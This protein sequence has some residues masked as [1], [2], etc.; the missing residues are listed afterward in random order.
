MKASEQVHVF[1]GAH[2]E[3]VKGL[4]TGPMS[5]GLPAIRDQGSPNC[6]TVD[7]W[8]QAS[9]TFAALTLG[10]PVGSSPHPDVSLA[11]ASSGP[12]IAILRPAPVIPQ[13]EHAETSQDQ[14][15]SSAA[16]F[17]QSSQTIGNAD[18]QPDVANDSKQPSRT[19][20]SLREPALREDCPRAASLAANSQLASAEIP[21]GSPSG[22]AKAQSVNIRP[23][24]VTSSS[25]AQNS[26]EPAQPL[27]RRE[28]AS[29]GTAE[30][31]GSVLFMFIF[32]KLKA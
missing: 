6:E 29:T 4:S 22:K 13:P 9:A 26:P 7:Q 12:G 8:D 27:E 24:P 21:A 28:T 10:T 16:T 31:S 19:A 5:L 14:N 25:M 15:L 32:A 18:D 20:A 23:D 1:S 2:D 11:K 3:H 17:Q 30:S